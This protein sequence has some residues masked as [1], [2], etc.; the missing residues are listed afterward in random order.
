[1]DKQRKPLSTKKP[2]IPSENNEILKDWMQN[3]IMPKMQPLIKRIDEMI[4][5]RIPDLQYSIKWGSAFYGTPENGWLIEVAAYAVSINIVFLSGA[6]FDPQPPL[7]TDDRSRY[8]KLTTMGDLNN[9]QV[10]DFI[11]QAKGLNGWK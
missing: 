9:P 3:N 7:G 10:I 6:N 5:E 2:P 4:T 11:E 1:M 8:I